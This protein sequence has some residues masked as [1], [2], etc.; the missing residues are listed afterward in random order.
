[1]KSLWAAAQVMVGGA[2][3]CLTAAPGVKRRLK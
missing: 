3:D 1:M 2:G